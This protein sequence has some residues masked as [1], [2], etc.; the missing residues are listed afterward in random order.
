MPTYEVDMREIWV[1][2]Y[3]VEADSPEEAFALAMA[4][5]G[6][7][8]DDRLE[9]SHTPDLQGDVEFDVRGVGD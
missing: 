3:E 9:Y 5:N 1:Q 4:G 8:L 2:T 7:P 6:D